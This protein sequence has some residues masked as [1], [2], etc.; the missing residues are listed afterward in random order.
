MQF[1]RLLPSLWSFNHVYFFLS[2]LL[3]LLSLL[4]FSWF[5]VS[6]FWQ[7]WR[8]LLTSISPRKMCDCQ[9]ALRTSN[10][11]VSSISECPWRRMGW[12]A[13]GNSTWHRRAQRRTNIVPASWVLIHI[14][15]TFLEASYG[16]QPWADLRQIASKLLDVEKRT[17]LTKLEFSFIDTLLQIV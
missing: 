14:R 9:I 16:V 8:H 7:S 5:W 2:P 4:V 10:G 15:D 1:L 6:Y 17:F 3:L 11:I 12:L 13:F